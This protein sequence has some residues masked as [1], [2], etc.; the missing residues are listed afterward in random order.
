MLF[1]HMPSYRADLY[2]DL[3]FLH[4][5]EQADLNTSNAMEG[6][7]SLFIRLNVEESIIGKA[8]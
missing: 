3:L 7:N 4:D 2:Q 8:G 6:Q 1:K 5:Q